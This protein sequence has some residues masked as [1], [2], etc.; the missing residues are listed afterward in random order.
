MLIN[1]FDFCLTD[2]FL[3]TIFL[4]G[5]ASIIKLATIAAIAIV[6]GV[7]K[8]P[9][10]YYMFLRILV[11]VVS[12]I[13]IANRYSVDIDQWVIGFGLVLILF[14]PVFPVH[15]RSKSIWT[16]LDLLAAGYFFWYSQELR[17]TKDSSAD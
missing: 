7:F 6:I 14:N 12:V 4:M 13:I 15:F 5:K 9:Y 10:G 1:E 11:S 16:V 3:L 2:F 8:M 17:R